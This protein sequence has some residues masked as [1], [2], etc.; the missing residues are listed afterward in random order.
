[1]D[2]T[3]DP[4]ITFDEDG[5]CNYCHEYDPPKYSEENYHKVLETIRKRGRN[6]L[7]DAV[8]GISGGCDSSYLA[9]LAKKEGLRVLLTVF[10]NGYDTET[11]A[12][13]RRKVIDYTNW[14]YSPWVMA[15]SEFDALHLAYLR[16]GVVDIEVPSDHAI[17]ASL[18]RTAV[19]YHVK[20]MLSGSNYVTESIMPPSWSYRKNDLPNLKDIYRQFGDDTPLSQFPTMS[21]VK[22]LRYRFLNGVKRVSLLNYVEYGKE[23]AKSLLKDEMGWTDYGHKH[24]ENIFT[25][26]YQN[27]ILP[28]RF[29]VDKRR[30]HL[31]NLI[32]GG[33][34][35]R[36]DALNTLKIRAQ[37]YGEVE[38]DRRIVLKRLGLS[39]V[40]FN[41]LMSQPIRSHREF[42][43]DEWLYNLLRFA[44]RCIKTL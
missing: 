17:T 43:S 29:G 25:R 23:E 6:S 1:M 37:E 4:D 9:Y 10:D 21:L 7:Y 15:Q 33:Q 40:E 16:A 32:L 44:N 14:D 38:S 13:N 11:A 19:K 26:F 30:P 34:I 28:T 20:T 22:L 24:G 2:T 27:Y 12:E 18:Y 35:T 8:L 36:E 5:V 41:R 3:A 42:A 31:S 39:N